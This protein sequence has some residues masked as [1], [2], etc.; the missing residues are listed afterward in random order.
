MIFGWLSNNTAKKITNTHDDYV[1][2]KH[3]HKY[4]D[5]NTNENTNEKCCLL[6]KMGGGGIHDVAGGLGL[7][8]LPVDDASAFHPGA[9]WSDWWLSS[10]W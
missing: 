5:T 8:L 2:Y 7:A 3:R 1:K 9:D 6:R 4:H 10:S